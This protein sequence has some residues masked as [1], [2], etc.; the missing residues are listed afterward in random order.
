MNTYTQVASVL[1]ALLTGGMFLIA[2]GLVPYWQSVDPAEFTQVFN[3]SLPFVGGTMKNLTMVATLA[4]IVAAGLAFWQKL[5]GRY[6]TTAAA[7]CAVGMFIMVPIYFGAANPT[8]AGG[9]GS[10]TEITAELNRWGQMHWVRTILS[11]IGMFCAVRAG[12]SKS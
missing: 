8:L 10:P 1:F 4:I 5:P 7:A 12:Y 9:A 2:M 3:T 6:W 11:L